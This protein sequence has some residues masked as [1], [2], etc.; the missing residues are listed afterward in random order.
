MKVYIYEDVEVSSSYHNYGGLVIIAD[1]QPKTHSFEYF[2]YEVK[3]YV[4]KTVDLPEPDAAYPLAVNVEPQ[5]FVFPNSGC[6]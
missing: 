3:A 6:C 1:E 4:T 2:D 5:T